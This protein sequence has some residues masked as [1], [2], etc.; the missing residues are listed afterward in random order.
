MKTCFLHAGAHKT[1]TSALQRFLLA[2]RD[3]LREEGYLVP[4]AGMRHG[5]HQQLVRRAVGMPYAIRDEHCLE[6]LSA[7]LKSSDCNNVILSAEIVE[8]VLSHEQKF[9]SFLALLADNQLDVCMIF[10][11]RNR[12]QQ[13]NSQY[14]QRTKSYLIDLSFDQFIGNRIRGTESYLT[15]KVESVACTGVRT[16]FRPYNQTTRRTGIARDFLDTIG[17]AAFHVEEPVVVNQSIGPVAVEAAR[18]SMREISGGLG[19]LSPGDWTMYRQAFSSVLKKAELVERSYCGLTT[20]VAR[21]IERA[22]AADCEA[23]ARQAWGCSWADMFSDDMGQ[24]FEPNDLAMVLPSEAQ[25]I[26]LDR[27]LP[28]LVRKVQRISRASQQSGHALGAHE[29]RKATV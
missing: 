20:R 22:S 9:R 6:E 8:T 28:P 13:L 16:I 10:Y 24:E 19:S 4:S 26:A 12:P 2:S 25:Q 23:F 29:V 1:G 18:R 21:E 27:I 15:K 17:L 7:E 5:S 14:V 11:V 3:S